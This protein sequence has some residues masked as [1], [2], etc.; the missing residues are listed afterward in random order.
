M[1]PRQREQ[2][3]RMRAVTTIIAVFV[4][5]TVLAQQ[6]PPLLVVE[7]NGK[8]G[9]VNPRGQF[10]IPPL[11]GFA[12]GFSEG[13]APVWVG[14]EVGFTDASGRFVI[15][16]QFDDSSY[17][18]TITEFSGGLAGATLDGGFGYI[19]RTGSFAIGPSFKKGQPFHDGIAEACD[20][21]RC[22]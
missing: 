21:T 22:G 8:Y 11:F 10:V 15:P 6:P 3:E 16:P 4:C 9:F 17:Q 1:R 12:W 5:S 18:A 19:D 7:V 13:L 20:Y 14:K 2:A